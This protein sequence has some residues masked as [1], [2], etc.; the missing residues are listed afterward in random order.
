MPL[1]ALPDIELYYVEQGPADAGE[2]VLFVHGSLASSRWWQPVMSRLPAAWRLIALDQRGSGR[3][4]RP[5]ADDDEAFYTIPRLAAD[6]AQFVEALGLDDYHLVAHA[7]GGA[8]ALEG[9]VSDL[10]RPRSLILVDTA[11]ALGVVTPAEA[12][13]YLVQMR[14]DRGLLVR[15]FAS[16]MPGHPPNDFFQSL[17]DDA[18]TMPAAAFTGPA[19]A[20][21]QWNV[22]AQLPNIHLP[23]LLIRGDQDMMVDAEATRVTFLSIP[24][25]G[26]L[27]VFRG[28]GHCPMIEQPDAF[29]D[30]VVQFIE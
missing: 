3:S 18:R 24:G 29:V 22:M 16:L 4:R 30:S 8:I 2:T 15:A 23:T 17:V 19:R 26:N 10:L 28:C 14:T 7:F 25:A 6:L 12:Y 5:G 20:L 27:E 1:I 13:P 11:P 21:A 9:I